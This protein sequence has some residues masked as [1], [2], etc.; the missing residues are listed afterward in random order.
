MITCGCSLL[1]QTEMSV[2]ML[3]TKILNYALPPDVDEDERNRL[4]LLNEM[5]LT[6]LPVIVAF[7]GYFMLQG[8]WVGVILI[9]SIGALHVAC[10]FLNHY[11]YSVLSRSLQTSLPLFLTYLTVLFQ[12][13]VTDTVLIFFSVYSS[14]FIVLAAFYFAASEFVYILLNFALVIIYVLSLPPLG[15][16][17]LLPDHLE[18]DSP[19][20][21]IMLFV[22]SFGLLITGVLYFKRINSLYLNEI[23]NKNL[24]ITIKNIKI[25]EQKAEIEKQRDVEVS[26]R[27]QLTDNISYAKHIQYSI[28][29]STSKFDEMFAEGFI[30]NLPKD[31]V[32]GD[33]YWINSESDTDYFAVADCTGHGVPGALLTMV[34]IIHLTEIF[35]HKVEAL[36]NHVLDE[37]QTRMLNTFQVQEKSFGSSDGMEIVYCK[38]NRKSL[39][40]DFASANLPVVV[41]RKGELIELK[42]DRTSLGMIS[43]HRH[44]MRHQFQLQ[45]GDCLYLFTDGYADQFGGKDYVKLKLSNFKNELISIANLPF[46]EQ[47]RHLETF[48]TE[49]KGNYDQIDDVLVVGFKV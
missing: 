4:N 11:S 18:T 30:L 20:F 48:M 47:K 22:T 9:L 13:P 31:I 16:A 40:L 32:S 46:R 49:W 27:K 5:I 17:L 38:L 36:P 10:L 45:K 29:P 21:T 28:L 12:V 33:F 37:L 25:K 24:K 41:V 39:L 2:K 6:F 1:I 26:Y 8:L 3:I 42:G 43:K 35:E 14:G 7:V 34:G 23:V 15:N 19:V 44:F